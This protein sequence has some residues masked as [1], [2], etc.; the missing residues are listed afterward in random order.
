MRVFI[1][2]VSSESQYVGSLLST[3]ELTR[4]PGDEMA[5]EHRTRGDVAREAL[6]QTFLEK[7]EFDAILMLDLDQRQPQDLLEK[8]RDSADERD[9]DMVCA[10]YYKRD[11]RT[12]QSL[13]YELGDGTY[14]YLPYLH[15]PTEGVHEISM[16]GFGCVL[17]RRRVVEAVQKT[18]PPGGNA[19]AIGPMPE[20]TG[21]YDNFGP[22]FRF[23]LKAR[24]LGY[25]LWLRA[26]TESLHGVTLWLGHKSANRLRNPGKWADGSYP[27]FE[28]RLRLHG[29][30]PEIFRQRLRVLEARKEDLLSKIPEA[31]AAGREAE[32]QLSTALFQL[33]GKMMECNAW[34]EWAEKYPAIERPDQLPTTANSQSTGTLAET[35][36]QRDAVYKEHARDLI[37][38]LPNRN[39]DGRG[40]G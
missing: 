19:I 36:A 40:G 27:L 33:E 29:M 30:T 8:L 11:T 38:A 4:R 31:K 25:K 17:I 21:D 6:V 2:G 15:P 12:V 26:D 37:T 23:F 24:A 9:L 14:P 10:H 39:G 13:C 16:T 32:E 34:L 5:I 35:P 28:E 7:P 1:A 18:M 20:I 22:D 3:F